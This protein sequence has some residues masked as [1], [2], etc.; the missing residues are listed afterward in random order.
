MTRLTGGLLLVTEPLNNHEGLQSGF[1]HQ[2][3]KFD[4]NSKLFKK[5][6]ASYIRVNL[7]TTNAIHYFSALITSHTFAQPLSEQCI[8]FF[9]RSS[10]PSASPEIWLKKQAFAAYSCGLEVLILPVHSHTTRLENVNG[11]KED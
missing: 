1:Q 10:A 7:A 4:L 3:Y 8:E 9:C 6:K 5:L 2:P 11:C